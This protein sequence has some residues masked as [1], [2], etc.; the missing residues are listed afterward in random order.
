MTIRGAEV[1][2]LLPPA[3][4]NDHDARHRQL[5][6]ESAATAAA[7]SSPQVRAMSFHSNRASRP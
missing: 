2:P 1:A 4:R 7:P 5:Q 3:D 6:D